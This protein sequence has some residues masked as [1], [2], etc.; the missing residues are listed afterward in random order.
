MGLTFE[1]AKFVAEKG[2]PDFSKEDIKAVK[3]LVL[4]GIGAMIAGARESVTKKTIRYV[5]GGGGR[6]ESS[7]FGGGLKTSLTNAVLVNGTSAHSME[8]ESIGLFTG[9]NPMSNIPVAFNVA[10]K[11]KLSGKA[12]IEGIIIGLEVQTRLGM[13]GLAH[14]IR[15]FQVYLFMAPLGLR[16]LLA[17]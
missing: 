3:D 13:G 5:K 9:S 12:V 7:I 10:E 17:P 1:V 16:L 14:L 15:D 11:F 6:D 8:L 2:Y 4:D